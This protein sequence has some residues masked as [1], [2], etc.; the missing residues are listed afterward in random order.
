MGQVGNRVKDVQFFI[1]MYIV[2]LGWQVRLL[3]W[4]CRVLGSFYECG[5]F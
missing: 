2:K 1:S 4:Y 5:C 3:S